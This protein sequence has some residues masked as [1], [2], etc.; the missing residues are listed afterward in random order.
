[1][2]LPRG[3][4]PIEEVSRPAAG[5]RR[6]PILPAALQL[7]AA[8]A[9][10]PR[11]GADYR[12]G[13]LVYA[14]GVLD[15]DFGS[16]ARRDFLV[17]YMRPTS[18]FD[19]AALLA[20]LE[21]NPAEMEWL[22]WTVNV[23][24]VPI[25]AIE[26]TPTFGR[27]VYAW[28]RRTFTHPGHEHAPDAQASASELELFVSLPGVITGRKLL[29]SGQV[30]PAVDPEVG[31]LFAWEQSAIE[32]QMLAGRKVDQEVHAKILR[33]I[34][35]FQ[36]SAAREL[37]NEGRAPRARALNFAVT[38]AF[39]YTEELALAFVRTQVAASRPKTEDA[40][41]TS[42]ARR[43]LTALRQVW[44]DK[45]D[46][47]LSYLDVRPSPIC[48][49]DSDG[50]CW[51]V[52]LVLFNPEAGVNQPGTVYHF[53]VDVS[54]PLPVIVGAMAQWSTALAAPRV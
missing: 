41:A 5:G 45:G 43:E 14:L 29:A 51:D 38:A 17:Q 48:R 19:R 37:R 27:A 39:Q 23:D 12:P 4:A 28:L 53:T 49:P 40:A 47:E 13:H 15:Y 34:E 32:R 22:T 1:M 10:A 33:H 25:C 9:G 18:P 24:G 54:A 35:L 42:A 6:S 44:Q 2:H 7:P 50:N 20:W 52:K 30:V 26:P 31:G 16:E 36:R 11:A 46:L 8:D 3:H 21:Q